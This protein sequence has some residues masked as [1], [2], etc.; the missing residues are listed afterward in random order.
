MSRLGVEGH[1]IV[2]GVGF[3][4]LVVHRHVDVALPG[5]ILDQRLG[6]DDLRDA[7]QLDGSRRRT[8]GENHGA[9]LGRL[10]RLHHFT[11]HVVLLDQQLLVAFQRRDRTPFQ[12]DRATVIGFE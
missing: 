7:R 12:R 10:H 11:R 4:T 9:V 1:V 5:E 6:M 8:I 3:R 2:I